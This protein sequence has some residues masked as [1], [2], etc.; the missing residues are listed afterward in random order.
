MTFISDHHV[1]S[2]ALTA[3]IVSVQP[4]GVTSALTVNVSY[5]SFCLISLKTMVITADHQASE[6]CEQVSVIAEVLV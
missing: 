4:A 3:T 5:Y 6:F 1:T 2:L